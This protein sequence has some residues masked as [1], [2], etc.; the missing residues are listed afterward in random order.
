MGVVQT[1]D[2]DFDPVF[3]QRIAENVKR[4][5]PKRRV[6]RQKLTVTTGGIRFNH[7][8]GVIPVQITIMPLSEMTVW[9][10]KEPDATNVYLE[11][12][13]DGDVLISM[14]GE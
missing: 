12:S 4:I 9:H 3:I 6:V 14:S 8:L 1:S 11:S 5:T 13:A 2:V 7:R 10:Y